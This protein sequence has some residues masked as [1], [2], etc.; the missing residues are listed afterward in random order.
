MSI[1]SVRSV[2]HQP[3]GFG[4]GALRI[5]CWYRVARRKRKQLGATSVE[6]GIVGNDDCIDLLLQ[7]CGKSCVNIAIA[8]RGEY[9]DMTPDGRTC[10][11]RFAGQSL[12]IGAIG[13]DENCKTPGSWQQFLQEPDALS[14]KLHVH[15]TES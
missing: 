12:G 5:D 15:A 14:R 11:V 2:A 1:S 4:R 10:A 3:P 8:G 9:F 7:N 13:I 6:Q